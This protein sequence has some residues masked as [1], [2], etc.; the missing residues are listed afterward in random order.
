MAEV[1]SAVRRGCPGVFLGGNYRGGV[2]FGDCVKN[3][4]LSADEIA[5][6]LMKNN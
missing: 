4:M 1:E 2:A 3:G 5:L 6:Y